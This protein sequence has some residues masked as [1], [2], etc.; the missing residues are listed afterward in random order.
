MGIPCAPSMN[1]ATKVHL[2]KGKAHGTTC[3]PT[4]CLTN[5]ALLPPGWV[6]LK[7]KITS[8]PDS[9]RLRLEST[10]RVQ[11]FER[12][13]VW[14]WQHCEIDTCTVT[15]FLQSFIFYF[16]WVKKKYFPY[17]AVTGFRSVPSVVHWFPR[18]GLYSGGNIH[19]ARHFPWHSATKFY[20]AS[21]QRCLLPGLC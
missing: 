5:C 6:F 3:N 16:D 13:L 18:I 8:S 14:W 11:D 12:Q 15:R 1:T 21:T 20:H 4:R 10:L 7:W 2:S 19:T 17:V 9:C